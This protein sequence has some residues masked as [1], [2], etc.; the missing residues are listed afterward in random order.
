MPVSPSYFGLQGFAFPVVDAGGACDYPAESD[1]RS[2]VTYGGGTYT[3]TFSCGPVGPWEDYPLTHSP[4]DVTLKLLTDAGWA[5]DGDTN[6]T[7]AW[8][9]WADDLPGQPDDALCVYDD[10]S[11]DDGRDMVTGWPFRHYEITLRLRGRDMPTVWAKASDLFLKLAREVE[12][13]AVSLGGK[14]YTVHCYSNLNLT[15]LGDDDP[16]TKRSLVHLTARLALR[17]LN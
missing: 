12:M 17:A 8:P 7:G 5:A 6:P 1:V 2:G 10:R 11:V 9:A 3:G 15:P 14:D 4:A 16:R 13:R